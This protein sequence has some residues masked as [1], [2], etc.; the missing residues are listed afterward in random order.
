M[1]A[2]SCRSFRVFS[3]AKSFLFPVL[4]LFEIRKKKSTLESMQSRPLGESAKLQAG[5]DPRGSPEWPARHL[6]K[7]KKM[8]GGKA[9]SRKRKQKNQKKYGIIIRNEK[10]LEN[11]FEIVWNL[12]SRQLLRFSD[13]ISGCCLLGREWIPPLRAEVG[14]RNESDK[15]GSLFT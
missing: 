13:E 5:G 11:P 7:T 1:D 2:L 3:P 15:W 6:T 4:W 10:I 14:Q 8:T 9:I 12:S